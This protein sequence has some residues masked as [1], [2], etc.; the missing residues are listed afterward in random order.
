MNNGVPM[1]KEL[2]AIR[3]TPEV[4]RRLKVK[5]ALIGVPQGELIEML[6]RL[7]EEGVLS[8][9]EGFERRQQAWF[10]AN[11]AGYEKLLKEYG[12]K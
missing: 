5:A 10:E 4:R 8:P 2:H 7:E 3:M 12:I 6:L 1:E 9:E 11:K